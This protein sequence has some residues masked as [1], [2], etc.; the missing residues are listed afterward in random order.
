MTLLKKKNQKQEEERLERKANLLRAAFPLFFVLISFYSLK[1]DYHVTFNTKVVEAQKLCYQLQLEPALAIL[2]QAEKADPENLALAYLLNLNYTLKAFISESD[3]DYKLLKAHYESASTKI[4]GLSDE[5]AYKRFMLAEME[6]QLA[7]IKGKR[8]EFYSAAMNINSAY[9]LLKSNEE[10]FPE[11]IWNKKTLGLINAYLSTVPENYAWAVKL[12]GLKG[13][14]SQGLA[15]LREVAYSEQKNAEGQYLAQEAHYLYAFTLYHIAKQPQRA[16]KEMQ[17]CTEDAANN[18]LST[19]FKALMASRI[20]KNDE[21]IAT[22]SKGPK[23]NNYTTVPFMNYMLGVA[24]LNAL[25]PNAITALNN[26][27]ASFKGKNY[28]KACLQKMSWYYILFP[29]KS[30][31]EYYKQLIKTTGSA[32]IEEDKLALLYSN[33][34]ASN[35]ILLKARL[36]SDGGNYTA[37]QK[38]MEPLKSSDFANT[39]EKAE[40]AYRKARIYDQ[41]NKK[42]LAILFYVACSKFALQSPEYYGAYS[43]L[44][45][46]DYYLKKGQK[47]EAQHYYQQALSYSANKEYTDSIEQK[48]KAG[49]K[50]CR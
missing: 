3:A 42:E 14:L 24:K 8:E 37:A 7:M 13:S 40:Y 28:I 43:C 35:A 31:S 16:W 5:L 44:Y 12:L 27:Y 9:K 46:G 4:E 25:D 45:L 17:N 48:A 15:M 39:M 18:G 50:A 1:A 20:H 41:L 49:L 22:I 29:N 2:S 21:V 34:P 30:K 19:F 33:K 11:F 23:G 10:K 32:I 36:L 26:Y 6:F 38:L 47:S